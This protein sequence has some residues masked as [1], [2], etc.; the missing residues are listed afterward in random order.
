MKLSIGP[1]LG[2]SLLCAGL[3]HAAA[4]PATAPIIVKAAPR[5]SGDDIATSSVPQAD[6][7]PT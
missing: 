1:I 6:A 4:T 3:A 5:S 7:T 2:A